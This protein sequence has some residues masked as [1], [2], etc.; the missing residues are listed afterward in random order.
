MDF[1]VAQATTHLPDAAEGICFPLCLNILFLSLSLS[2]SLSLFPPS[3][4]N[5]VLRQSSA[6]SSSFI[7]TRRDFH[8]IA[9]NP[10][11]LSWQK[12]HQKHV[13]YTIQSAY[14]WATASGLFKYY[15]LGMPTNSQL[16]KKARSVWIMCITIFIM[17]SH[18]LMSLF[19]CLS[20]F[21][22]LE[23]SKVGF[24]FLSWI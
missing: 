15:V 11:W 7:S 9:G 5:N 3:T 21:L 16:N 24:F 23:H 6:R 2:L 20:A 17:E 10:Y 13:Q 19:V 18:T 8:N 14:H 1:P 12:I 22:K 4:A